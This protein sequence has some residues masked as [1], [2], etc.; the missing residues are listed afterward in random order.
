MNKPCSWITSSSRK[1]LFHNNLLRPHCTLNS[2]HQFLCPILN[3][4]KHPVVH[5]V[6]ILQVQVPLCQVMMV[7]FQPSPG[8]HFHPVLKPPST[9]FCGY[10]N[11]SHWLYETWVGETN[12]SL[13]KSKCLR[14]KVKD[15]K[16]L[17]CDLKHT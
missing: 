11:T 4:L 3:T 2:H 13:L 12:R 1:L 14:R 16:T 17:K 6:S 7:S 9:T 15:L 5:S 8:F 10:I